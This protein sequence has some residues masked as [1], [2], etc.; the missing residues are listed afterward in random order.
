MLWA[1][2]SH[3]TISLFWEIWISQPFV[4]RPITIRKYDGGVALDSE[5][6]RAEWTIR[7]CVVLTDIE[8][9]SA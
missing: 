7:K 2:F 1:F 4:V 3:W 6:K 5:G 9:G 8:V